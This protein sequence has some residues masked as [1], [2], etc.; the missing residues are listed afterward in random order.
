[1]KKMTFCLLICMFGYAVQA[2]FN[3]GLK[4]GLNLNQFIT[5]TEQLSTSED[6]TYNF[7]GGAFFR[8][9]NGGVSFTNE[10]LYAEKDAKFSS[11]SFSFHAKTSY[12]DVP[13]LVGLHFLEIFHIQTGPVFSFLVNEDVNF[14]QAN[15]SASV[16]LSEDIFKEVNFGWQAGIGLEISSFI[17]HARYEFSVNELM[18]EFSVQDSPTV[19]NPDGRN[20]IYQITLAYKF[21]DWK[22]PSL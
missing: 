7:A 15:Q 8:F 6:L 11:D 16:S 13:A 18:N 21:L 19:F 3:F 9:R 17:I 5:D 20:S 2:Q 12:I 4:A 22:Q 10:I 1:M 14:S